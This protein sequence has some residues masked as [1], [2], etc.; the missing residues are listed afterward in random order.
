M[1]A[2]AFSWVDDGTVLVAMMDGRHPDEI[3]LYSCVLWCLGEYT[4]L[5]KKSKVSGHASAACTVT[6]QRR[7]D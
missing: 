6:V 3:E 7:T 4:D 2:L 5:R 1:T